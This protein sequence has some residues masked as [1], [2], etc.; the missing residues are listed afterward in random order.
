MIYYAIGRATDGGFYVCTSAGPD[1]VGLDSGFIVF[2]GELGDCLIYVGN[3][4]RNQAEK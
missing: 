2:A 4:L 1:R 3:R